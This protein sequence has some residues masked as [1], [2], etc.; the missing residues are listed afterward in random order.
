MKRLYVLYHTNREFSYLYLNCLRD[1]LE[2]FTMSTG[3]EFDTKEVHDVL[4]L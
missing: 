1:K 4:G 3:E 2:K